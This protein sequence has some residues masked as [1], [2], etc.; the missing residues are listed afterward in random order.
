MFTRTVPQTDIPEREQ[1]EQELCPPRAF[2][3]GW[4]LAPGE[5]LHADTVPVLF[6]GACGDIRLMRV[7]DAG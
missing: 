2:D 4:G 1:V 7:P 6:C 5:D 3:Q